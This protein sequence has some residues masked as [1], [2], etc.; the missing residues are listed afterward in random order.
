MY[1]YVRLLNKNIST[2]GIVAFIG[3]LAAILYAFIVHKA[4]KDKRDFFDRF[5]FIVY[6]TVFGA[7]DAENQF[8]C[9]ETYFYR[10]PLF[11]GTF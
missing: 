6:G 7:I 11:S 2:Y 8:R 5:I 9:G 10:L 4:T 3:M 1:P